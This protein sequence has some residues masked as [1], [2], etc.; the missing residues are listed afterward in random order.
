[1]LPR[2][3]Q[4]P[5]FLLVSAP[6]PTHTPAHVWYWV[7]QPQGTHVGQEDPEKPTVHPNPGAE[8]KSQTGGPFRG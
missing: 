3:F 5:W 2:C 7:V 4:K 8:R 6:L 1:M